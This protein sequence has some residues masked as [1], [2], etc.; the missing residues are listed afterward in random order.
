MEKAGKRDHGTRLLTLALTVLLLCMVLAGC[1]EKPLTLDEQLELGVR[2]L[3]DLDY[4]NAVIAFTAAIEL[5]G[6]NPQAYAGLYMAYTA[7]D[8]TQKAEETLATAM[9]AN[10]SDEEILNWVKMMEISNS[11]LADSDDSTLMPR[12]NTENLSERETQDLIDAQRS[13]FTDEIVPGSEE[14]ENLR[15]FLYEFWYKCSRFGEGTIYDYRGTIEENTVHGD[16]LLKCI[17]SSPLGYSTVTTLR[18]EGNDP[19]RKFETYLIADKTSVEWVMENIFNCTQTDIEAMEAPILNNED[20][21]RYFYD[22]NFFCQGGEGGTILEIY[23]ENVSQARSYYFVQYTI[24]MFEEIDKTYLSVLRLKDID[25]AFYWSLYYNQEGFLL[26][27][28]SWP[29][30]EVLQSPDSVTLALLQVQPD[31]IIDENQRSLYTVVASPSL[32]M[33]TGPDTTYDKI[34]SIP[35]R[36]VVTEIGIKEG[37]E[38]WTVVEYI[39]ENGNKFYGWVSTEF[40]EG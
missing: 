35:E 13:F 7:L 40:I 20:P 19:L 8:N 9:A 22:G 21:Y 27:E 17:L 30:Q 36:T 23:I 34:T 26:P 28:N 2:Y 25:G 3:N 24:R 37:A 32:N 1:G 6:Q 39:D 5:D 4:E 18:W 15:N 11:N 38:G 14:Y 29:Y 16:N 33:R 10:V 31:E 12:Q